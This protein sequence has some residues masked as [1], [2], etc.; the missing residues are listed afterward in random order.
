MAPGPEPPAGVARGFYLHPDDTVVFYG[1]S[2]TEQNFYNQWVELYTV[3]RFPLMRVHFFDAGVG[4]DRVTGGSG[5]PIDL[6]LQRDVFSEKPSVITIMLGMNDGEYRATTPE[7]ETTYRNGYEHILDS[8]H[9]HDPQARVTL[10]GPSPYD[11][12]S[13]PP[14]FPGGYNA[15]MQHFAGMDERLAK[16]HGAKFVNLNPPV[17]AALEKAEAL[18]PRVAKLLLPDRVHPD[19][20]AHWVMAEALLKGWNAPAVVASVTIDGQY[21]RVGPA[22]NAAVT[23]L[24]KDGG[25]LR[26]KELDDA[27]PLPLLQENATTAMLLRLTDIEQA[28][29]QEPLRV[30]GLEPGNYLLS[31]DGKDIGQFSGG[32]TGSRDRPGRVQHADAAAGA[33]GE[34]DGA[35]PRRGALHSPAHAGARR[36]YGRGETGPTGCRRS[37]IRWKTRSTRQAAPVAASIRAEARD[38]TCGARAHNDCMTPDLISALSWNRPARTCIALRPMRAG[39]LAR[40]PLRRRCCAT[41]PSGNLFGLTQNAGMGWEPARL[42]DPEF[43]ILSTHGGL[44]AEDGTPIA[45]GFH[46]GTLGSG[47][48]GGRSARA[49]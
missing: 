23:D 27:L 8:I 11:D 18:D 1:D 33:A 32:A 15:V 24:A 16:E 37:R 20:L 43:L 28:L 17:V 35:R 41:A 19:P 47:T 34:L 49:N 7:I 13:A 38:S 42:L 26:W 29:N 22:D 25:V 21:A 40:C 36:G 31:I 10:L 14:V 9:E 5:G 4:G 3:T 2:I 30:T 46:T 12:V 45:L 6:R 44:R 48:A 39:R